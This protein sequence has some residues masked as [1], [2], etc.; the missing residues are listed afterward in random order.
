MSLSLGSLVPE[1]GILVRQVEAVDRSPHLVGSGDLVNLLRDLNPQTFQRICF[2]PGGIS[3]L[4]MNATIDF[5]P[6]RHGGHVPAALTK[7]RGLLHSI[8]PTSDSVEVYYITTLGSGR[9]SPTRFHCNYNILR[10]MYIPLSPLV[11]PGYLSLRSSV[12]VLQG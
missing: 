9:T 12:P 11:F 2:R 6:D 3:I 4:L 5:K 7:H 8:D 1:T 10:R